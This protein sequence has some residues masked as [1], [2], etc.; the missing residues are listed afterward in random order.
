V[1]PLTARLVGRPAIA[2]MSPGYARLCLQYAGAVCLRHGTVGLG[3]FSVAALAD[4]AT[5]TLAR[6]LTIID[7]RNPDPNALTPQRVEIDLAEGR[8]VARTVTAV[9]GSPERPLSAEAAK[10]KFAACWDFVP[11]LAPVQ[12]AVLWDTV[13]ALDTIEDVRAL[14]GLTSPR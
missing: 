3:D 10:T 1:P 7:D 11:G 8:T 6:R 4:P 13:S 14:A 9:F 12:A 5:L 2:N